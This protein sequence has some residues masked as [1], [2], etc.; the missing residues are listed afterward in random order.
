[1]EAANRHSKG[2]RWRRGAPRS[3][4]SLTQS[5]APRRHVRHPR[6]RRRG[7]G[8]DRKR[9][10][11]WR[12]QRGASRSLALLACHALPRALPS[13]GRATGR[14]RHRGASRSI[15]SLNHSLPRGASRAALG[16]ARRSGR[17]RG[18]GG[19]S[20]T[21]TYSGRRWQRGASRSFASAHSLACP[22]L[23]PAPPTKAIPR[24]RRKRR[25]TGAIPYSI[26]KNHRRKGG[27]DNAGRLALSLRSLARS[28]APRC[29]GRRPLRAS[30]R[31]RR[32]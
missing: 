4:A 25:K 27:G 10:S 13:R 6:G 12:R 31:A 8:R 1:M 2:R 18:H 26:T 19:G 5:H 14:R 32:E 11:G 28:L 15:A 16:E 21:R 30:P 20:R 7:R 22:A 23:P 29:H 3:I 24:A 17:R 9:H